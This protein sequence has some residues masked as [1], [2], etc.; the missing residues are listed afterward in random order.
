MYPDAKLRENLEREEEIALAI[1][2][3]D[4]RDE[5]A[6]L[7]ILAE[8]DKKACY[9]AQKA[10]RRGLDPEDLL[11]SA[12]IGLSKALDQ[13]DPE[14]GNRFGTFAHYY[15]LS[16]IQLYTLEQGSSVRIFNTTASKTLLSSYPRLSRKYENPNTGKLDEEGRQKTIV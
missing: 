12:R 8:Y 16:E 11:R 13:F 9:Y 6:R 3:R 10:K 5:K 1:K 7:K 15:I 4:H 14:M 2:W